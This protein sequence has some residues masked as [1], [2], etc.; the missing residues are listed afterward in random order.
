MAEQHNSSRR[1]HADAIVIVATGLLLILLVPV[2]FAKPREQAIR[3]LCAANLAQIGKA[4]F[5]YADDNEGALPRAGG[6]STVWGATPYWIATDRRMAFNVSM[7]D[8]G[9]AASIEPPA[10]TCSSVKYLKLPRLFVCKA[11][12]RTRE[13]VLSDVDMSLHLPTWPISGISGRL[14]ATK[15]CSYTYHI[16]YGADALDHFPRPEPCRCGRSSSRIISPAANPSVWATFRPDIVGTSGCLFWNQRSGSRGQ[17][18]HTP[19]RR[20]QYVRRSW[21]AAWSLRGEPIAESIA[22]TSTRS[23]RM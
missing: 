10:S 22:T 12:R 8:R 1:S 17:L 20:P 15:H 9:G 7:D 3:T 2:L 4:M 14:A 5:I 6:P 13:F 16:P 11:D 21:T 19:A 18:D 23:Q